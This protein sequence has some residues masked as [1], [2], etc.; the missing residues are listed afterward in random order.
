MRSPDGVLICNFAVFLVLIITQDSKRIYCTE[1][2]VSLAKLGCDQMNIL[3]GKGKGRPRTDQ[4]RHR[5][6]IEV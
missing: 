2:Q 3:P 4:L 5:E 6:G 1:L